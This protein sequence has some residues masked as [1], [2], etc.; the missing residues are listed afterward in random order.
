MTGG[1]ILRNAILFLH[2][3]LYGRLQQLVIEPTNVCNRT[4]FFCGAAQSLTK[5]E[6]GFMEW[7]IFLR[8]A[9]EAE[10]IRP[11]TVSLYAHG[12][13]LLHPQIIMMVEELHKR[14]LATELVTNGDF[15]TPEMSAKLLAAGLH[16]LV[17]SHPAISLENWQACRCE[18][19]APDIDER[20]KEA[21]R[22]WQDA[23]NKVTLRCLVFK[24]KVPKKVASAREYL[25]NWL[26]TPGVREVEFWLYQPW[27]D[28]VLEDQITSIHRDPKI[29]SLSLQTLMVSWNGKI[30]PCPYD[31]HG[32]LVLGQ[33]PEVSLQ[34]MYSSKELRKFRRQTIRRSRFR[35]GVCKKC[36]INRVSA[37]HTHVSSQEYMKIDYPSRSGWINKKGRECWLQLAQKSTEESLKTPRRDNHS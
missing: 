17:I 4:C 31:I 16:R 30:S 22:I 1:D 35:P 21:V 9:E 13:P 33:M 26:A 37:V 19:F 15:L 34:E 32:D 7:E 29:C 20:L 28:H 11:Q 10:K 12:E 5:I 27:P 3:A 6:R 25:Q 24:D 36:L 18:P 8:L 2:G 14:R 23:E